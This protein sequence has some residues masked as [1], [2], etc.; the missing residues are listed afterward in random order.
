MSESKTQE[1]NII[2]E[3]QKTGYPTEIVGASIMQQRGW[4]V[5]HNPS[6]LDDREGQS[7]EFDIQAFREWRMEVGLGFVFF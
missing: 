7:R 2:S 3:L 5:L 4:G 1:E 6:Y